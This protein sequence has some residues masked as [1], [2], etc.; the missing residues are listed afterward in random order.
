MTLRP[1][2][3]SLDIGVVGKD[4]GELRFTVGDAVR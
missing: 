2:R 3:H 1:G 4:V